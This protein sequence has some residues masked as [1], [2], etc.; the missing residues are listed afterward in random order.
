M[1]EV[2]LSQNFVLFFVI[3]KSYITIYDDTGIGVPLALLCD[4]DRGYRT[5]VGDL[6]KKRSGQMGVADLF[7][8]FL[9]RS[10]TSATE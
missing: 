6:H 9:K 5:E 2:I 4:D 8:T 10:P 3:L 7:P 1:L